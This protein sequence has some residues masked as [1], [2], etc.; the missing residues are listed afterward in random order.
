MAAPVADVKL[1]RAQAAFIA[2]EV[3]AGL[4]EDKREMKTLVYGDLMFTLFTAWYHDLTVFSIRL[5]AGRLFEE[6]RNHA[7]QP[8]G[9]LMVFTRAC[10]EFQH[11]YEAINTLLD[12]MAAAGGGELTCVDDVSFDGA[13][14]DVVAMTKHFLSRENAANTMAWAVPNR[15]LFRPMCDWSVW[16]D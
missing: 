6:D 13:A 11:Y 16:A 3:F 2:S 14:V 9:A 5:P 7:G 4:R 10:E 15:E 1:R 12:A 8:R